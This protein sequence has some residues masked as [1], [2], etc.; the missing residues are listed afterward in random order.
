MRTYCT[1]KVTRVRLSVTIEISW[2][3]LKFPQSPCLHNETYSTDR[4]RVCPNSGMPMDAQIRKSY[5]LNFTLKKG[6]ICDSHILCFGDWCFSFSSQ[7]SVRH[8]VII[9]LKIIGLFIGFQGFWD[10]LRLPPKCFFSPFS[11]A[12]P[13]FSRCFHAKMWS[14]GFFK[15]VRFAEP[16]VSSPQAVDPLWPR[17]GPV[18]AIS[19]WKK[20][21]KKHGKKTMVKWC[22]HGNLDEVAC[23]T[24]T[25]WDHLGPCQIRELP[26][27]FGTR[28]KRDLQVKTGTR[29]DWTHQ[30]GL[31]PY[32]NSLR[33]LRMRA[34]M[35]SQ[36][37]IWVLVQACSSILEPSTLDGFGFGQLTRECHVS[38]LAPSHGPESSITGVNPAIIN[39]TSCFHVLPISRYSW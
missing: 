28:H 17:C 3:I 34:I 23:W 19:P 22:E 25:I 27:I 36:S 4:F 1:G 24:M 7:D 6:I 31:T 12:S 33:F 38:K 29:K 10:M 16:R 26:R 35:K 2:H 15:A 21:W 11:I 39:Q 8:S 14:P 18:V 32:S 37:W 30:I 5:S 13:I 9:Q 20:T